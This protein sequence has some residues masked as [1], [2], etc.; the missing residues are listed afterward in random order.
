MWGAKWRRI[1]ASAA[2]LAVL[3]GVGPMAAAQV[4]EPYGAMLAGKL[5]L[6]GEQLG[7]DGYSRVAGPFSG[8][9]GR[10]E[11][12]R[13]TLSVRQGGEYL[14]LG[15]CDEDCNDLDLRLYNQ[16]GNLIDEDTSADGDPVINLRAGQTGSMTVEVIMYS[17][18]TA[19][20]YYALNLYGR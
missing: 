14:V 6:A 9:L 1:A 15:V 11:R 19:P 18:R 2:S 5:R 12:E 17:C 13:H 16:A 7:R 20:C 4:Q 3:L 8:G 10:G